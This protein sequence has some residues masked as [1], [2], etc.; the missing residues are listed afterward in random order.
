M[1]IKINGKPVTQETLAAP[2]TFQY[3]TLSIQ[4]IFLILSLMGQYLTSI[5]AAAVAFKV[6]AAVTL[7]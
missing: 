2:H 1:I 6:A 4:T 5:K 7:I 3:K